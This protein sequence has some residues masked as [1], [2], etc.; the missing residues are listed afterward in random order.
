[1][2]NIS[3]QVKDSFLL[4]LNNKNDIVSGDLSPTSLL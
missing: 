4:F 3:L 2:L 1:M